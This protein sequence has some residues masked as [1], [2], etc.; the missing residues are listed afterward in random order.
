MVHNRIIWIDILY[1]EYN[2]GVYAFNGHWGAYEH[3]SDP[4]NW[5][6]DPR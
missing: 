5:L 1:V 6:E 2:I 4:N 3:S